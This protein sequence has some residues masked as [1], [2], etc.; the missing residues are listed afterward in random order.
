MNREDNLAANVAA[1]PAEEIA[2]GLRDARAGQ[3][4]VEDD[5]YEVVAKFYFGA[6]P[7]SRQAARQLAEQTAA[8]INKA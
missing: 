5:F 4:S 3:R 6:K 8:F 2:L 7:E 1:K